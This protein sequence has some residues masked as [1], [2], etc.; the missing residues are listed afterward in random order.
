MTLYNLGV[1]GETFN[2]CFKAGVLSN[3]SGNIVLF[4]GLRALRLTLN[5]PLADMFDL[6]IGPASSIGVEAEDPTLRPVILDSFPGKHSGT[7]LIWTL[8]GQKK[9][10]RCPDFRGGGGGGNRVFGT[11]KCPVYQDVLI[12]GWRCSTVYTLYELC[13][14]KLLVPVLGKQYQYQLLCQGVCS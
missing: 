14:V 10:L 12:S 9:H 3:D 4:R 11:A 8:L 7:S 1:D 5:V 2:D 13:F 6:N